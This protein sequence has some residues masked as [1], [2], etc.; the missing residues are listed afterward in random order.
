MAW[1]GVAGGPTALAVDPAGNLY[2][3]YWGAGD[4]HSRYSG[5]LKRDAQGNCY[6]N[7][8]HGPVQARGAPAASQLGEATGR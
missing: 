7:N 3:A 4:L 5:I 1:P 8:P 2:V 6:E